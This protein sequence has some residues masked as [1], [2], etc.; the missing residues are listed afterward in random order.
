[1]GTGEIK[2]FQSRT[3]GIFQEGIIL[4]SKSQDLFEMVWDFLGLPFCAHE[5]E[6]SQLHIF[7]TC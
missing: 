4:K 3:P 6:Y 2:D 5:I 1:M 7:W